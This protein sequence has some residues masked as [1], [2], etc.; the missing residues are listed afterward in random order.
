MGDFLELNNKHPEFPALNFVAKARSK[1]K[2][3][4][5]NFI[6]IKKGFAMATDG[7]RLH[8]APTTT[9]K[10]GYYK[11]VRQTSS[12]L[13]IHEEKQRKI[14]WPDEMSILK[15]HGGK[16]GIIPPCSLLQ[17]PPKIFSGA[18]S[19]MLIEIYQLEIPLVHLY[20][21]DLMGI[22]WKEIVYDKPDEPVIFR[23]N[24]GWMAVIMPFII[25]ATGGMR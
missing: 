13:W 19:Q 21:I 1:D 20:L 8:R 25:N 18:I 2:D 6:K 11:V 5:I 24:D 23:N 4:D 3:C 16:R 9:K 22:P 10:D 14:K 15:S 12:L 17:L 7:H